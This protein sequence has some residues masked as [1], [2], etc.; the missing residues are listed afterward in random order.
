MMA[1]PGSSARLQTGHP[2][3]MLAILF[4]LAASLLVLATLVPLTNFRHWTVRGLDFPRLQIATALAALIAILVAWLAEGGPGAPSAL[5]LP[6]LGACLYYQGRWI[7]PYSEIMRPEVP[8]ADAAEIAGGPTLKLLTSNVLM[9]NR[10]SHLLIERVREERPD[11]L[12]VVETDAWW[13]ARLDEALEDM[14]HR[15]AYPLDNRYGMHLYSRLPL[16]E[17]HVDFLVE[18]DIPSIAARLEIAGG[19]LR[20]HAIHPTPPAPGENPRST[21]RDVEL[22][23]LAETLEDVAEP[24]IVTG[25]LNDVAWSRTTQLFR[26]RSGL[27]DPRVGRG[28]FNTFHADWWF[29]RWPLDHFFVSD[30][31]RVIRMRRLRS[32]GS[33][34]FPV[35]IELVLACSRPHEGHPDG[36]E[37]DAGLERDTRERRERIGADRPSI[38]TDDVGATARV[39]SAADG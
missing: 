39:D 16:S 28:M 32:I 37:I 25:D 20:L 4:V 24:T 14:P 3:P 15:V 36:D 9:D 5:W 23:T 13:Q 2:D 27:L 7:L 30:H 19:E 35:L 8:T 22:L 17:A 31:Y 6:V 26:R 34:H 12:L 33:D 11:V 21:E 38:D 18:D 10:D 1:G 29:M